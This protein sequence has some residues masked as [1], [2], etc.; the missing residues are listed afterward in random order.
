MR[1]SLLILG[2]FCCGFLGLP[3]NVLAGGYEWGGLGP[4]ACGMGGA[5]TAVADDWTAT[6]WNPAGLTETEGIGFGI[7]LLQPNYKGKDGNSIA[8]LDPADMSVTQGDIF[9]R[10]Y[11]VEPTSFENTEISG[12]FYQPCMGGFIDLMGIKVGAGFYVP[13]GNWMD[14]DDAITDLTNAEIN[15]SYF[16]SMWL[17]TGNLSI[18]KEIIPNLSIGAGLNGLYIKNKFEAKKSYEGSSNPL[19][20]DYDFEY[21]T[22]GKGYG[23]EGILGVMFKP[24]PI[25]SVGAVYRTGSE[26]NLDGSGNYSQTLAPPAESSNY[27]ETFYHPSTY[28]VGLTFKPTAKILISAD[29]QR[30]NWST[31]KTVMNFETE[32]VGLRDKDIDWGWEVTNRYRFGVEGRLTDRLALRTGFYYDGSPAPDEQISFTN[33]ADVDRKGIALGAG[34]EWAKLQIDLLYEYQ[35]GDRSVNDIEYSQRVNAITLA[36]STQ[37]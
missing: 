31:W 29:W 3:D 22:E 7:E 24:L 28:G 25:L 14:W 15:A 6:Y 1:K 4:R 20:I 18:A 17:M 30:S 11:P 12:H 34:Y 2:M 9:A 5:F 8:N 26:I 27:T 13:V 23:F 33:I 21:K 19:L 16:T 35:W 10:V 36:L 37:L 32:G